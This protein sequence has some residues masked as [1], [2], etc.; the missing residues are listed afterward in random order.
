MAQQNINQ[1]NFNKW[2]IKPVRKIFDISLASDEVDYN[3]EV[4]FSTELIANS[5]GNK[6]PVSMD[7]NNTG[8]TPFNTLVYKNY[9][10]GNTVVSLNYYNP[11]NDNL[12]CYTAQT[13]CDIGL[14]GIDNGLVTQMT[15]E[16]ISFTMG[17]LDDTN[18]FDRLSFDRR[19]KLFQVTGYTQYPNLRFSGIPDNTLYEMVSVNLN[20][21]GRYVQ[22]Y[23]GFYQGFFKLQGYDYETFPNRTNKGWTAEL[24][25]KARQEDRYSP[26]SGETTLN[27]LYPNNKNAFFYFGT[28]AENKFYHH[29]SGT[30]LSNSGYTRV[31]S[32]L[33]DLKT[34]KC[35]NTGITNSNCT[36]VYEPEIYTSQ[37]NLNCD[38]GCGEQSNDVLN[39][40]KDPKLDV[41]SNA[42]MVK[43]SGDPANPIICVRTIT[44]TGGCVTADCST[45]SITYTTGYTINNYCSDTPIFDYCEQNRPDFLNKEH[46]FLVDIVWERYTY[47]D[48]CDLYYRGGLSDITTTTYIESLSN[49][50]V[51]LIQPPYTQS[52][53]TPASTTD[54]IELNEK[55]LIDGEYRL[56]RLKVFVNGKL[57][58]TIENFEEIIPRGLNTE[59]E[60]QIG[61]PFNISWGGGAQG[62]HENLTFT[63]TPLTLTGLT[64]QQDPE[65]LPNNI[66]SG[67]SLSG[68][69]TNILLE[70]N[71]GGTFDG[72]I[73]QFRFYVEPLTYPE[74]IHN[75]DILK[76]QF[77]LF[78]Y[79]CPDCNEILINDI[80]Y[81]KNETQITFSSQNFS[82]STH[83]LYYLPEG[84]IN[85]IE[86]G[87]NNIPS[88][89]KTYNL[90]NSP[91]PPFDGFG[92]YYFY[93]PQIDQTIL[94]DV[95]SL[96]SVLEV[97]PGEYLFVEDDNEYLVV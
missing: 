6:L 23:G 42:L 16:T 80:T 12:T 90:T 50:T 56:G 8:S 55:W 78:D 51:N 93:F 68:L 65:S 43:L 76:N 97:T 49:N 46:W 62:L 11:N 13:L 10:T 1:Y 14:T 79:R 21:Y 85:R 4:V 81:V 41:L 27:L 33:T 74:V 87:F 60:R 52:G 36:S 58:L 86:I 47:F 37:H 45:T 89:P 69:S 35:T 67:T 2:F 66:L 17:L 22:Q 7:L 73:S 88:F 29:A 72:G 30:P 26:N 28:R 48:L 84:E 32:E 92:K 20:P 96:N 95:N 77:S 54:I 31:T 19:L 44:F 71:F 40:D 91:F 15:G 82:S 64:Y 61:V 34:C 25:L 83:N 94:V 38:C 59:K 5:D 63:G 75:F 24:L 18:K 39:S 9:N 53:A 57:N 3:Q 70:Q